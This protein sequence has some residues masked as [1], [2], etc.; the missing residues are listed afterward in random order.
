M[1][2]RKHLLYICAGIIVL[3]LVYFFALSDIFHPKQIA[4]YENFTDI[5][6]EYDA[7]DEIEAAAQQYADSTEQA[8]VIHGRSG[9]SQQVI[10]LTFDGMESRGNMEGI[11][12]ALKKRGWHA[13]FF[14]EGAN[15]AHEQVITEKLANEDQL[16]GNYSFVG[17]TKAERLETDRL[18]EQ[19][20]KTQKVLA[21]TAGNPAAYFKLPETRYLPAL[22][23]AAKA[24]GL[25]YAVQSDIVMKENELTRPG[26]VEQLMAQVKPGMIIS[27]RLDH[28]V[29]IIFYEKK[30]ADVPAIDMKPTIKDNVAASAEGVSIVEA[31]QNLCEALASQEYT[32]EPVSKL[33]GP[34]NHSQEGGS[35]NE[36]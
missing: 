14:L 5:S 23:R 13:S 16:I 9:D 36:S 34:L 21:L 10:Y 24:S 11:L 19:F 7:T 20:C 8:V 35:G 6:E 2:L 17:I 29:P 28:P 26:G 1:H 15:A 31:V 12:K 33:T 32:V 27:I 30:E 25:D 22:L 18:L 3:G 4:S